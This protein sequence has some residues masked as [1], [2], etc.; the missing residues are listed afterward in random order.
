MLHAD[1]GEVGEYEFGTVE[2]ADGPVRDADDNV[3]TPPFNVNIIDISDQPVG[4]LG[5]IVI[6]TI[7]AQEDGFIVIHN[8][9]GSGAPGPV[10]GYERVRAGTTNN[11]LVNLDIGV[12]TALLFPMLHVDTGEAGEYEFG[13]VEGADG[14]VSVNDRVAF[15]LIYTIPHMRV[16]DQIVRTGDGRLQNANPVLVADSVLAGEHGWLVVHADGGGAPGPV[17]GYT[18]VRS[19]TNLDVEVELDVKGLTPVLWPMLHVDTGEP[20][21]YEFGTVEGVDGPVRD[22]AGNVITFPINAAPSIVFEGELGDTSLTVAQALI[23]QPGWLAIH[24]NNDGSPGPVI[25]HAPLRAGVNSNVVVP[26]APED[27]G[28]LVFPML[29]YDTNN[30][31][32]YE[33]GTVEGADGPVAVDGNVVVGPL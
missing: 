9:N 26:L 8:D 16:P 14:P 3:I 7:T 5:S 31:G 11:I 33:F 19:G 4:V 2:G 25:G 17:I 29:H 13:T 32:L 21:E 22:S 12:P 15:T 30:N 6:A 18:R 24:A 28:D 1:T 27:A 23:D 20:R 10:V